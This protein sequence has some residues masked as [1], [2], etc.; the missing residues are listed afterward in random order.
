M[1]MLYDV[2][3]E[4]RNAPIHVQIELRGLPAPLPVND[5]IR[6]GGPVVRVFRSSSSL[7]Q[8]GSHVTF[9][10]WVCL[11]WD[12][13]TGPAYVYCDDLIRMRYFEAYLSGNPPHCHLV[14]CEYMWIATPSV[15][16]RLPVGS[17]RLTSAPSFLDPY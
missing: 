4:R 16:P 7:V 3:E 5:E 8:V 2:A 13:P 12:V 15:D 17:G 11:K 6:I 9:A 10:I 14:G 1:T